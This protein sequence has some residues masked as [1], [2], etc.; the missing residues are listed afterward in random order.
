MSSRHGPLRCLPR[1]KALPETRQYN[2]HSITVSTLSSM[3]TAKYKKC[4]VDSVHVL[5]NAAGTLPRA[6]VIKRALLYSCVCKIACVHLHTTMAPTLHFSRSCPHGTLLA[7][8]C[9]GWAKH[10]MSSPQLR[11][12]YSLRTHGRPYGISRALTQRAVAIRR[13]QSNLYL[14]S[15]CSAEG[16]IA[17]DGS[18]TSST[19]YVTRLH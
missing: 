19:K 11:Q 8:K 5:P 12:S 4:L 13:K 7:Y 9:Q 16:G 3:L 2:K 18:T 15:C 1:V 17:T 14:T 6:I 10:P